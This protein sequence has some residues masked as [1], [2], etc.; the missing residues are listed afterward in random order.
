VKSESVHGIYPSLIASRV[1][2][3]RIFHTDAEFFD[4]GSPRDYLAT[5][6]TLAQRDG[7]PL[8][9]GRDCVIAADA[10]LTNTILWDR[11]RIGAGAQ[12]TDCIVADEV[13]VPERARYAQ[14]SLVMRENVL[15]VRGFDAKHGPCLQ[16]PD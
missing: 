8:D 3:V 1:G 2:A 12:L 14:C 15:W 7:R 16:P 9:R 5:A 11:V 6:A 4:I 13:T 10:T